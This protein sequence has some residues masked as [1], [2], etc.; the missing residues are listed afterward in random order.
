[1]AV[2]CAEKHGYPGD[3]DDLDLLSIGLAVVLSQDDTVAPGATEME[4]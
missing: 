4:T 2:R 1:M 3:V